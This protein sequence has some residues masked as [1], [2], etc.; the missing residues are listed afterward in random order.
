MCTVCARERAVQSQTTSTTCAADGHVRQ[1]TGHPVIHTHY[2]ANQSFTSLI[3]LFSDITHSA[4]QGHSVIHIT[5]SALQSYH[6][7]GHSGPFS[8]SHHSFGSSVI[9]LIRPFRAIQSFTSLIRLFSHITHSAIQ[10]YSV[11]HIT[12]SALQSY[13]SFGHSGPFSHSHHL[14]GSSVISLIR[15]FRAIQSF[16]SLIRRSFS[17]PS[18]HQHRPRGART[19]DDRSQTCALQSFS[20]ISESGSPGG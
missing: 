12:H 2:S 14:F 15:P 16:T 17:R 5:H 11:I 8:H 18:R 9:S 1:N 4:I 7:F 19:Q 13:H 6:S 10:G 3:R 20:S